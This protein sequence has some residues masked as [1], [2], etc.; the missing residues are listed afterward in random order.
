MLDRLCDICKEF[1]NDDNWVVRLSDDKE[2][3][4]FNGHQKCIDNLYNDFK[5]I[6]DIHKLPV[7]KVLNILNLRR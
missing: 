7:K 1:N 6:K 3:I 4:E 2:S 5:N